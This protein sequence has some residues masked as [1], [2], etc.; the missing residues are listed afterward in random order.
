MDRGTPSGKTINTSHHILLGLATR[1]KVH[2][3]TEEST[4]RFLDNRICSENA[5]CT[6][7]RELDAESQDEPLFAELTDRSS[8]VRHVFCFMRRTI[9][10]PAMR[11]GVSQAELA[12]LE[13]FGEQVSHHS[14][15]WIE[16]ETDQVV[17]DPGSLA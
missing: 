14:A 11:Q 9:K 12:F 13:V 17:L 3:Q 15:V 7:N 6:W 4:W 1:D 10:C 8:T 2:L 16:Q 5:N